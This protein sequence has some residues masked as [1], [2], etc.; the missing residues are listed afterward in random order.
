MILYTAERDCCQARPFSCQ[1]PSAE[2]IPYGQMRKVRED[3][4]AGNSVCDRG[5]ESW[6]IRKNT[7]MRR[8]PQQPIKRSKTEQNQAKSTKH[9]S[10]LGDECRQKHP[11]TSPTTRLDLFFVGQRHDGKTSIESSMRTAQSRH[12]QDHRCQQVNCA[13]SAA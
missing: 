11:Q 13:A 9:K 10:P 1:H 4:K 2:K 7:A 12:Q 8:K 3:N 6:V 5:P